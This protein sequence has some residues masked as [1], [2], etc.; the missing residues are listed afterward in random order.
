ME[1]LYVFNCKYLTRAIDGSLQLANR[2]ALSS[3]TILLK[4]PYKE[5]TAAEMKLAP[6]SPSYTSRYFQ[7][8]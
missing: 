1:K 3:E 7:S 8:P 4:F 6:A 2:I 5:N